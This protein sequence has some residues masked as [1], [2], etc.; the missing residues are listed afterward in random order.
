VNVRARLRR[1]TVVAN[2]MSLFG[3]T[4]LTSVVG[5]AFWVLA[6][7]I[8]SQSAIGSSSAAIS[9][10][11]LL[12]IAAMLGLGTLL[13]GELAAGADAPGALVTTAS[14]ASG[15]AGLIGGAGFGLLAH[16]AW[17][18]KFD[19]FH[20]QLGIVLFAGTVGLS[21]ASLVLDDAMV[22]LMRARWQLWRNA[23]FS[24]LKLGLLPVGA[25][26]W[27]AGGADGLFASWSL[28]VMVSLVFLWLLARRCRAPVRG[29]PRIEIVRSYWRTSLTHHWLNLSVAAPRLA[30]PVLVTLFLTPALNASFYTALL[31]AGFAYVIPSHLSTALF[32]LASGDKGALECELRRTLSIAAAV[33]AAAALLFAC[34]SHILL[35][36]FGPGY[37]DAA[38]P[39]AVLGTGVFATAVKSQ[40][41]A[42][43]RVN[44]DLGRCALVSCA[45]SALEVAVPC[46][47]LAL[48]GGLMLV[49]ATWVLTMVA[50]AVVLWPTVA[51]AAGLRGGRAARRPRAARWAAP[52]TWSHSTEPPQPSFATTVTT[53]A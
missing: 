50:E 27:G 49:S 37:V 10:M 36:L 9:A 3:T 42:V 17:P 51:V 30:L 19:F 1:S 13:I 12:S 25:F 16:I 52:R 23:L 29:R 39:L 47:A 35:R 4:V 15:A 41:M 32:A 46:A 38:G 21:S 6:A 11:Q 8:F 53:S 20:G 34:C 2:A 28:G 43:C 24:F 7:H 26:V 5:F 44:G 14:L 18:A 33:S 31:L 48:G 45:G 22:G 40:Y